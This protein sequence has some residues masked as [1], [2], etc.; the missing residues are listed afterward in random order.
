MTTLDNPHGDF[1][2]SKV[3][4]WPSAM[5]YGGLPALITFILGLVI[6]L[7]GLNDPANPNPAMGCG[8]GCLSLAI[9]ITGLVLG[10]KYHRDKELGGIL[11]F[12]RG[13]GWGI[14]ASLIGGVVTAV[15]GLIQNLLI[16]PDALEEARDGMIKNAQP[17]Q[18]EMMESI[19][20]VVT[21]PYLQPVL[22]ILFSVIFG[23][24]VALIVA[25]IMKKDPA[26]KA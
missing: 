10:M 18:E 15:G 2:I 6:Y 7:A 12:G 23:G 19:A 11:P 20:N 26:P 1:D 24:I 3:S 22:A 9:Y 4:V 13:F 16:A 14:A 5:K 21:N 17:G 25:A 8:I